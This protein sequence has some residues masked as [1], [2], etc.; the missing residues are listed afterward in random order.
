MI[1]NFSKYR[2]IVVLS[3]KSA[4][5]VLKAIKA[6]I[7]THGKPESLQTYNGSEFVNEELKMYLNKNRIHHIRGS[8]YHPQSQGAV[9]A[10]SRTVQ[11]YLY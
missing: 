11:N 6:C 2:W 7:A 4:I 10:F 1:D 5:T 3:D 8:Q 9:E